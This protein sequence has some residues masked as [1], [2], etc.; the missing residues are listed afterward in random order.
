MTPE[1]LDEIA[2]AR[3]ALDAMSFVPPWANA[4]AD[5]LSLMHNNA[6]ALIA[7]ARQ[8][9]AKDEEIARLRERVEELSAY[10]GEAVKHVEAG[11]FDN[12]MC[13]DGRMCGCRGSTI[14]DEFLLFARPALSGTPS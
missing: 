8:S 10:L 1:K 5:F 13:C 9:A 2:A 12:Q 14:G 11:D 3:N 6:P 7:I 4:R